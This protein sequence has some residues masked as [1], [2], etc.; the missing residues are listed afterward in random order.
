VRRPRAPP[1]PA[2]SFGGLRRASDDEALKLPSEAS[3]R[4]KPQD[5]GYR[6]SAVARACTAVAQARWGKRV[7]AVAEHGLRNA[8]NEEVEGI[9]PAT[10][11]GGKQPAVS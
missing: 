4:T 5:G 11:G 8:E 9:L 10:V 6:T 1:T 2:S 3:N 7:C